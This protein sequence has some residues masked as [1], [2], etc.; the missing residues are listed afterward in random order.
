MLKLNDALDVNEVPL[1]R[2]LLKDLVPGYQT[3]GD[4]VDW[5]WMENS[6]LA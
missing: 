3:D 5:V 6:K 4:V 1:I 2:R